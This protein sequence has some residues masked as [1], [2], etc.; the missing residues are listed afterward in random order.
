MFHRCRTEQDIKTLFRRVAKFLHPDMGG[1]HE[2]MIILQESYDQ[3]LESL[4]GSNK[5]VYDF[6]EDLKKNYKDPPKPKWEAFDGIYQKMTERVWWGDPRLEII[7]EIKDYAR[8]HEKFKLDFVES[9]EE[10]LIENEYITSKQFNVLVNIY[11][12]FAMDE[13]KKNK[14]KSKN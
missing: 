10:F 9:V 6:Y 5:S 1:N 11:Y 2:L 14:E 13:I 4:K 7:D 8:D 3:A 12:S